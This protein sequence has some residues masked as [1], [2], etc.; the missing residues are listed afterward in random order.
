MYKVYLVSYD[1]NQPG[2]DYPRIID[3]IG[4]FDHC[5]VLKSQWFVASD[6]TYKEIFDYLIQFVDSTDQLLVTELPQNS[7]GR[8]SPEAISWLNAHDVPN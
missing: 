3:A 7:E 1:L 5:Q 4:T 8:I 6:K 2:Q